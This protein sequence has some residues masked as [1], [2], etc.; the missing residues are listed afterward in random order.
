MEITKVKSKYKYSRIHVHALLILGVLVTILP[1]IWMVLTSFMTFA[2][3]VRLPTVLIPASFMFTNYGTMLTSMPFGS[4][5]YNTVVSTFAIT[6][7]EVFISA[8]AAYAF[9]RI[10][11]P[12]KNLIF[13]VLL[14]VLMI[15]SQIFLLPQFIII[16]KLKLL[17]TIA[18]L[19]IPNL[20]SVFGTFLLR[21]FMMTLPKELDEAAII[22]GCNHF[23][24]FWRI[25]LPLSK[26]GLFAFAVFVVRF[27][28]NN[29]L[30]PLIVNSDQRKMTLSAGLANL[31]GQYTTN[32]PI[33]MAG[34]VMAILP[35]IIIFFI[36]Q[37]QFIQGIAF[38]GS[39]Y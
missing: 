25:I 19:I 18:A 13:I 20:F 31:M 14:S 24:I 38:A 4:Y 1:F 34:S 27:A 28:W 21:Q 26:A 32:Y 29:L 8:M 2:E 6:V 9:A 16:Q 23:S 30:W 37:K 5:Y 22:D 33:L 39:K 10:D 36:F 15:P 7:G 12:F 17:N 35:M 11:F 3:S